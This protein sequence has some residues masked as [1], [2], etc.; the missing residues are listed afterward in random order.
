MTVLYTVCIGGRER[1][2]AGP[3]TAA[4]ATSPAAA[5][6]APSTARVAVVAA[7]AA[8]PRHTWQATAVHTCAPHAAGV[9][10]PSAAAGIADAVSG[11]ACN[12]S[13]KS[14]CAAAGAA[15]SVSASASSGYDDSIG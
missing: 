13:R 4:S 14:T 10:R 5:I 12:S 9:E 7:P 1:G 8:R 15:V 3:T 6:V 2:K 11:F